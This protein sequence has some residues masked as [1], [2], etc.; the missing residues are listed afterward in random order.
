MAG[1]RKRGSV[2]ITGVAAFDTRGEQERVKHAE[3]VASAE[4]RRGAVYGMGLGYPPPGILPAGEAAISALTV[5]E[6]NVVFGATSGSKAHLFWMPKPFLLADL[7]VIPR[8]KEVAPTLATD[9]AGNLYGASWEKGGPLFTYDTNTGG[10]SAYQS[11]HGP[12]RTR[13]APFRDDGVGALAIS[14]DKTILAALGE[15][16]GRIFLLN[17]ETGRSKKRA[18]VSEAGEAFSSTLSAGS[19][20]WFYLTGKD[21]EL[22]RLSKEGDVE[23]LGRYLPCRKGK[24]YVTRGSS[25]TWS[26]AGPLYGGTEDGHL[27]SYD[28]ASRE[29]ISHGRGNDIPDLHCLA[30]GADGLIYGI[31]GKGKHV[32]HLV[33]FNPERAE[34][35]DLGLFASYG[36]YPWT[37]YQI[38]AMAAGPDGQLFVGEKDRQ[39]YLF[40]YHPPLP[41]V[42]R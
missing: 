9:A 24:A 33:S 39:G 12:I 8:V 27:F 10:I 4:I 22:I 26:R 7:G 17:L 31:T 28:P 14:G 21:G 25:F 2:A 1:N 20:D 13:R 40:I 3:T 15:R 19:G 32:S 11:F 30:E 35:A 41:V 18:C 42:E 37:A 23:R 6:N 36:E 5:S 38:G 16:S 29:L 34:W